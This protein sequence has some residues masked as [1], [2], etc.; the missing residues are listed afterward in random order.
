MLLMRL[1]SL[2]WLIWQLLSKVISYSELSDEN[3]LLATL[4]RPPLKLYTCQEQKMIP[5]ISKNKKYTSIEH[6]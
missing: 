3:F 2:I 5:F 4:M 1:S 6:Y